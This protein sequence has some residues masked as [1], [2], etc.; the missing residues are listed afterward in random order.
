M[1]AFTIAA[2]ELQCNG[3]IGNWPSSDLDF[4]FYHV[5]YINE[6][7]DDEEAL[8]LKAAYLF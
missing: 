8:P 1:S 6:D 3:I 4:I 7:H 2:L 5:Q